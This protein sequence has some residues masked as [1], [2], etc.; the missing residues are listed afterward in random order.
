[1]HK[2]LV[3]LPIL[4]WLGVG[5]VLH[6][7]RWWPSPKPDQG[8]VV[9]VPP[10]LAAPAPVTAAAP[11]VSDRAGLARELHKELKRVGCYGGD[12]NGPWSSASRQAMRRFTDRVNAKLPV[13]EPDPILLRLV[14]G[15]T[16]TV[17]SP[18]PPAQQDARS[19]CSE[20]SATV[21]VASKPAKSLP[22]TRSEEVS[23]GT[24]TPLVIGAA[25]TAAAATTL[26]PPRPEPPPV[27]AR[28]TSAPPL[29]DEDRPP[30][31]SPPQA[32]PVPPVGVYEGRQRPRRAAEPPPVT[33]QKLIRKVERA[34]G[35]L[36][37]R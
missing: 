37:I 15:Q 24:A 6:H 30:P 10:R 8:V 25:S 31:R 35:S 3:V 4:G 26:P 36:G 17:C 22:E 28:P 7:A 9:F 20:P 11:R 16:Q 18:C 21:D 2:A 19:L 14:A 34:L 32:G 13:D 27:S 23:G 33:V 12:V 29:A 5:A 1:M